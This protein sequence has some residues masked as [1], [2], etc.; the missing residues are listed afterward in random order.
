MVDLKLSV[1]GI[2]SLERQL[3]DVRTNQL[4]FATSRA[5]QKTVADAKR[6]AAKA[7]RKTLDR[8]TKGLTEE[9]VNRGWIRAVWPSKS[10]V[11]RKFK[12][13]DGGNAEARVFII[14]PLVNEIHALTF[15]GRQTRVPDRSDAVVEPTRALLKG[16]S[17]KGRLK[18]LN[19]FG[20][21]RGFARGALSRVRDNDKLYLNVPIGNTD[22][23]TKHLAPGLYFK[24]REIVRGSSSGNRTLTQTTR[25]LSPAQR[26]RGQ[27]VRNYLVMLLSY[28]RARDLK[29]SKWRYREV[30][31]A[32]YRKNHGQH[33]RREL[34]NA[35]RTRR[36]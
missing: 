9:Q 36:R 16:L 21:I 24:G 11:R 27:R 13:A 12:R 10:D 3:K 6:D 22:R 33:F 18:Q 35:I 20:N 5:M 19:Q 25:T 2:A 4:P 1:G 23:R 26:R 30:V 8:P 7:A 32:S 31:V 17:G 28:S 29:P 15:G 34:A 14:D